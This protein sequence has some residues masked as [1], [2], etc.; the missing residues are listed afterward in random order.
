MLEV[1]PAVK[2]ITIDGV[3]L[4]VM[5]KLTPEPIGNWGKYLYAR[6]E[7]EI[8]FCSEDDG[9]I[10]YPEPIEGK[11]KF[12]SEKRFTRGGAGYTP[13]PCK[14]TISFSYA[15]IRGRF[16]HD[17]TY[18]STISMARTNI[19]LTKAVLTRI[20]TY[21]RWGYDQLTTTKEQWGLLRTHARIYI[22]D[23]MRQFLMCEDREEPVFQAW[24][25]G[26]MEVWKYGS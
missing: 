18:I 24:L 2:T 23:H 22:E 14:E 25:N 9:L 3:P 19:Q 20:G 10:C 8:T 6:L 4:D 7:Q 13:Y 1:I 17:G 5:V 12:A 11:N 15:S 21:C 16:D 26:P